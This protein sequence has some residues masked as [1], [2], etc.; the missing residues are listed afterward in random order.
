MSYEILERLKE[1]IE[2]HE[3]IDS[4]KTDAAFLRIVS[5]E[6]EKLLEENKRMAFEMKIKNK[7]PMS[8][9]DFLKHHICEMNRAF[10]GTTC[11]VC[12]EQIS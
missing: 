8:E 1:H 11:L 6:V 9:A 10:D 4:H 7:E 5:S 3:S 12:N 2:F